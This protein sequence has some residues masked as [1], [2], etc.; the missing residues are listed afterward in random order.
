M[1]AWKKKPQQVLKQVLSAQILLFYLAPVILA[2]PLQ[3]HLPTLFNSVTLNPPTLSIINTTFLDD[4]P[5]LYPSPVRLPTTYHDCA[6]AAM[7][8]TKG[9]VMEHYTFGRGRHATYKLPKTFHSGT[10]VVNLDM[11]YD[12]QEDTMTLLEIQGAAF[13]L[14]IQ[15]TAGA[16]FNLGGIE[17]V[18]PKKQLYVTIVGV[19]AQSTS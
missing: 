9:S 15:C 2:S 17:A 3:P 19:M 6:A 1:R 4:N 16:V 14:A 10:C 7:Q 5:C 8:I 11:V 12:D 18:G 13:A